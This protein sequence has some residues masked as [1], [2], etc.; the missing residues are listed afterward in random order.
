MPNVDRNGL[1][2]FL[3]TD[4]MNFDGLLNQLSAA[5]ANALED[6]VRIFKAANT[7][8]RTAIAKK[9]PPTQADPLFVW[10]QD[11]GTLAFNDGTGWVAWPQWGDVGGKPGPNQREING[12]VRNVS[13]RFSA[14]VKFTTKHGNMYRANFT[15]TAPYTPPSGWS[16]SVRAWSNGSGTR[17]WVGYQSGARSNAVTLGLVSATSTGT[18]DR[19]VFFEWQLIKS[20]AKGT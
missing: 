17:V 20:T 12:V 2:T 9:F 4:P 14:R 19:L 18:G 3:G 1:P 10:R 15:W 5:T 8:A 11:N 13:G 7:S 6:Q 16:W